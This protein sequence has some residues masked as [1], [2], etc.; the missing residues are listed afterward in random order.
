MS[1]TNFFLNVD[2]TASFLFALLWFFMPTKLLEYN[3]AG[4]HTIISDLPIS[5]EYVDNGFNGTIVSPNNENE[6][7]KTIINLLSL[8]RDNILSDRRG[9]I[10]TWVKKNYS[11]EKEYEKMKNIYSNIDRF[12]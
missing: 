4:L 2:M 8:K 12:N 3:C 6:L 7:Q 11:W 1:K 5:Y 9:T 10:R